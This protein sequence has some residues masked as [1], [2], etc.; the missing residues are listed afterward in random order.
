MGAAGFLV[1]Q[2]SFF[3]SESLPGCFVGYSF[4]TLRKLSTGVILSFTVLSNTWRIPL[5]SIAF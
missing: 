4:I 2:T 3:Q 5:R 1:G